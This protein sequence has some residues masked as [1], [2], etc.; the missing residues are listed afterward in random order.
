MNRSAASSILNA[1]PL[2]LM[3]LIV[4]AALTRVLPHPPNF[5]PVASIALFGGAW[6]A[7]RGWA[8]AVPLVGLL[9]SDLVLAS[10]NGGLYASWFGGRDMLAV[11]GCIVLTTVI[12]FRMRGKVG[13]GSILGYSLLGAVLFYLVTNFVAWLG[14]PMYPQTGAGLMA[15]Y[16]AGIPFFRWSVLGTLVYS[17]ALFGGFALL[18]AQVPALRAHTA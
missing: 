15:S 2:V 7:S 11:Y 6:F 17:A 5:S 1:G 8:V 16:V 18:R 3:G 10:I 4:L 13:G 14:N 9:I 12:G